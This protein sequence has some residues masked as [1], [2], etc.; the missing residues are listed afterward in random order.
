MTSDLEQAVGASVGTKTFS[1]RVLLLQTAVVATSRSL[2]LTILSLGTG[3]GSIGEVMCFTQALALVADKDR[4]AAELG[5]L[6]LV[7]LYLRVCPP[8]QPRTESTAC[9]LEA[10]MSRDR[11]IAIND[12]MKFCRQAFEGC[13]VMSTSPLGLA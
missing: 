5:V 4:I 2:L 12:A 3:Y 8:V 13:H 10:G 7:Q 11:Q 6:D 1:G 9:G